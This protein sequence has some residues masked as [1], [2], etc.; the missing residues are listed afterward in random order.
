MTQIRV[1]HVVD[2]QFVAGV[3]G[4]QLRIDQPVADGGDNA[5]PTPTELFV[6]GLAGCVAHYARRFLARHDI[7]PHG[8]AVTADWQMAG[9]RPARVGK[10]SIVVEP[11]TGLPAERRDALLAVA[12]HCTVHNSLARPPKIIVQ[13][14]ETIGEHY[15]FHNAV[16]P[17]MPRAALESPVR[18]RTNSGTWS[19]SGVT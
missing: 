15:N 16:P 12:S 3:R 11:P 5:G 1:T 18:R 10:V 2:D 9:G 14:A 19:A 4:H 7:D 17:D 13:F 8:L 6:T